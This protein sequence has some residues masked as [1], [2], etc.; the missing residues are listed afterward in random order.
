VTLLAHARYNYQLTSRLWYEMFGQIQNDLFQRL[1]V[2]NLWGTGPRYAL[3]EGESFH[4]FVG[5]AYMF[6][7]EVIDPPSE[8]YDPSSSTAHRLSTY[9]SVSYAY[10]K[11][12]TA[13]LTVYLQPRIDAPSDARSLVEG[14]TSFTI[15]PTLSS[16]VSLTLRYDS[17]P[18]TDVRPYDLEIKN[19]LTLTF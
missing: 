1:R 10:L 14:A 13:G 18:P 19:S 7:S 16:K 3:Y 12:M 6:E 9:V 4:T 5:L 11:I 8:G 15:T 2:R 17:E